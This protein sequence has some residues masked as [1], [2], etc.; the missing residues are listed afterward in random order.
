MKPACRNA[1]SGWIVWHRRRVFAHH[2]YQTS[3]R[4][5]SIPALSGKNRG[6]TAAV[7]FS[8]KDAKTFKEQGG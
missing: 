4:R 2:S 7:L 1:C 8:S 6:C 5:Y 3:S